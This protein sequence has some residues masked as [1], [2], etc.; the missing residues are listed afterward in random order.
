MR[1]SSTLVAFVLCAMLALA[2]ACDG[3]DDDPE[4]SPTSDQATRTTSGNAARPEWFP[5]RFPLPAETTVVSDTADPAGGG[6]VE[7]LAPTGFSRT[8]T[9]M[10]LNLET[11]SHGFIIVDRSADETQASFTL[12]DAQGEYNGTVTLTPSG[13]QT[14]IVV[15]LTPA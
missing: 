15:T 12:G 13:E 10:D 4:P 14:R 5:A 7:F 3:G 11:P 6:T 2:A 8:I 1:F 9:I